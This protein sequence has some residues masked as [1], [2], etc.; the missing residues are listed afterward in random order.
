VG[1]LDQVRIYNVAKTVGE[2]RNHYLNSGHMYSGSVIV[3][4]DFKILGTDLS[5]DF[6]V[7][8]GNVTF[9]TGDFIDYD[10]TNDRY[11]FYIGDVV[12][13]YVNATGFHDGAPP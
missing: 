6:S 9:A 13:G 5:E 2:I 12:V 8:D 4:D 3:S 11:V 10:A 7:V 1:E